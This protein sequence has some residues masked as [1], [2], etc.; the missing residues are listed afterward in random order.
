MNKSSLKN[1]NIRLLNLN[2]S[3][4]LFYYLISH[5][6]HK[7][8]TWV[9]II[10]SVSLLYIYRKLKKLKEKEKEGKEEYQTI[11]SL[12]GS[13]PLIMLPGLSEATQCTILAKVEFLNIGGSPKDRV[14]LSLIAD[15][16][17][18]HLISPHT[19]CI[20]FEGTV[21]STGISL[22]TIARAKGYSCHIVMP[23]D[24]AIE[25]YELLVLLGATVERVKP[26]SIVDPNHFVNVAR[27]R[28]EEMNAHSTLHNLKSRGFFCNQFENL[29]NFNAHYTTTGPEIY[30]QTKGLIDALVLGAGTGGTIAGIG[31]Y[32][33]PR[34][35]GMKIILAD[36]EGSGLYNKVKHGVMYSATEAE[37]SRKRHQIDTVV[38]G[39]GLKV[40]Q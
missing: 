38:E 29:S 32:L 1:C 33:K 17:A 16:E 14:A 24:V 31:R 10:S 23:E 40:C 27:K 25:K 34:M 21:G 9:I 12:I 28:A 30:R 19:G 6:M 26:C 37:G 15:A 22:A 13:T 5:I 18:Q 20:L 2:F 3:L 36:P 7:I 35:K 39:V 11:T 4:V 8:T